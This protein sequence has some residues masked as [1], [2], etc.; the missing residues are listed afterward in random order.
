MRLEPLSFLYFELLIFKL[1]DQTRGNQFHQDVF[2]YFGNDDFNANMNDADPFNILGDNL[3]NE[4]IL[5]DKDLSVKK[6]GMF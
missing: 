2:N 1:E 5:Q 4:D 3:T 6:L